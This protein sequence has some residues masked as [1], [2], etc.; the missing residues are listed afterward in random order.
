MRSSTS[1]PARRRSRYRSVSAA[2]KPSSTCV[3]RRG[4]A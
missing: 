1:H 2:M 4:N 3:T